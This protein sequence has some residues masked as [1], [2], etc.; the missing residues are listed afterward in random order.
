MN[1]RI[2]YFL[3]SLNPVS[4]LFIEISNSNLLRIAV[5]QYPY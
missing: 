4:L 5:S 1:E 3:G 2:Y